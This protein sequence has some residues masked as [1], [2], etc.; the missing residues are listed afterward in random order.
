[1]KRAI[2]GPSFVL[3]TC[4]LVLASACTTTGSARSGESID[5]PWNAEIPDRFR[6]TRL[7]FASGCVLVFGRTSIDADEPQ[8]LVRCLEP[9]DGKERW[10]R[11]LEV[12]AGLVQDRL[13][14]DD[15]VIIYQSK[16]RALGLDPRT[17]RTLWSFDPGG[18]EI[19][20]AQILGDRFYLSTDRE[21]IV[22]LDASDGEWLAGHGC[23]DHTLVGVVAGSRGPVAVVRTTGDEQ[24]LAGLDLNSAGA[25]EPRPPFP[26]PRGVWQREVVH[27]GRHRIVAGAVVTVTPTHLWSLDGATGEVLADIERP[28]GPG[29]KAVV[30]DSLGM[31]SF[32]AAE[33]SL[34]SIRATDL[35]RAQPELP[36]AGVRIL[37][38]SIVSSVHRT[39]F[40]LE[41]VEIN[42][43]DPRT[44][45]R[46]WRS[47]RT[48][49]ARVARVQEVPGLGA[50]LVASPK[51]VA[52][53]DLKTGRE[54]LRRD[55]DPLRTGWSSIATDGRGLY[56]LYGNDPVPRL[57]ALPLR[58]K[59]PRP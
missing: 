17:G 18:R 2:P 26:V 52:L 29:P 30:S 50:L 37:P 49:G 5:D 12:P 56:V 46:I 58:E 27:G 51:Q 3:I 41:M 31:R 23:P 9:A 43:W 24:A 25:E 7:A 33:P 6:G 14:A 45:D 15:A 38:S 8:R 47:T 34:A 1:M 32:P 44:F 11:L 13:H 36:S 59:S 21:T 10:S 55:I 57:E 54:I 48:G 42:R 39:G 40:V 28:P 22:T 20:G 4:A 19:G 35:R 16:S 53:L